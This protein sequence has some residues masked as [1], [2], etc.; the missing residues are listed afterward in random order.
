MGGA[1]RHRSR[2]REALEG[3]RGLRSYGVPGGPYFRSAF[4][5]AHVPVGSPCLPS[6]R[7]IRYRDRT[8]FHKAQTP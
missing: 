3:L 8:P 1:S 6:C 2:G 4:F 7:W 5:A